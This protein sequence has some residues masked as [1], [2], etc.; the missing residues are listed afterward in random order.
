MSSKPP[1]VRGAMSFEELTAVR[2]CTCGASGAGGQ[3]AYPF[4]STATGCCLGAHPTIAAVA[5]R[6]TRTVI[7]RV[8]K[9]LVPGQDVMERLGTGRSV[10]GSRINLRWRRVAGGE[11]S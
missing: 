1:L 5:S 2:N 10:I 6:T 7:R 9:H 11:R 4:F 3:N 8:M